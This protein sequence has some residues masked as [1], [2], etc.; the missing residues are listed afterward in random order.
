MPNVNGLY[1]IVQK[2]ITVKRPGKK[3]IRQRRVFHGKADLPTVQALAAK[4]AKENKVDF[5]VCQVIQ[6][7]SKPEGAADEITETESP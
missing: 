2:H 5:I 1:F 6:E 7:F 4:Y 3:R